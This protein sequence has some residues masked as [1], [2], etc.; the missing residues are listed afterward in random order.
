MIKQVMVC[1]KCDSKID[2]GDKFWTVLVHRPFGDNSH[3]DLCESCI[4]E[5]IKGFDSDHHCCEA[6]KVTMTLTRRCEE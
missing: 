6:E 3:L 4:D 2:F 5:I 1:D